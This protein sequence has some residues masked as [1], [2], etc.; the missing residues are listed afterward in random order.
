MEERAGRTYE[1]FSDSVFST[2]LS[3]L[4]VLASGAPAPMGWKNVARE[5]AATALLR[6]AKRCGLPKDGATGWGQ[7]RRRSPHADLKAVAETRAD[8]H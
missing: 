5:L 6:A 7:L 8:V 2:A 1:D 3:L 4:L